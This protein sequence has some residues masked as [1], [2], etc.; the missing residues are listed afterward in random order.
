MPKSRLW[1]SRMMIVV[2]FVVISWGLSTFSLF[3]QQEFRK[4]IGWGHYYNYEA[5]WNGK[6]PG[7]PSDEGYEIKD[8]N[9]KLEGQPIQMSWKV[10]IL[11]TINE[12]IQNNKKSWITILIIIT[13]TIILAFLY[14]KKKK[15]AESASTLR[16]T[17][18]THTETTTIADEHNNDINSIQ[19]EI[20]LELMKWEKQLPK[21]NRRKPYETLQQWLLR[22][23]KPAN[24]IPVYEKVRYGEKEYSA[25]DLESVKLWA[26]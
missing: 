15:S 19:N 6:P 18:Q 16:P 5:D 1:F 4:F 11:G 10:K 26:K 23:N 24:I 13:A 17:Q 9:E 2:M 12:S 25:S 7:I 8:D 3:T 21:H 20:R 14:F 22:L